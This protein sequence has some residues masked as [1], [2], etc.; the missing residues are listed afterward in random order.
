MCREIWDDIGK[1]ASAAEPS[2][3]SLQ[4][5][6]S[7]CSVAVTSIPSHFPSGAPLKHATVQQP[8]DTLFTSL[9]SSLPSSVHRQADEGAGLLMQLQQLVESCGLPDE[10]ASSLMNWFT[11]ELHS[12]SCTVSLPSQQELRHVDSV[13]VS[14]ASDG[15]TGGM[16]EVR[17]SEM[18]CTQNNADELLSASAMSAH[19][20]ATLCSQE[21]LHSSAMA[22]SAERA[23]TQSFSSH[24][25]SA[26][27]MQPPSV[28]TSIDQLSSLAHL[29]QLQQTY[30]ESAANALRS[31]CILQQQ[32]VSAISTTADNGVSASSTATGTPALD[33]VHSQSSDYIPHSE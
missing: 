3:A 12:I 26:S 6:P 27:E 28:A 1:V 14:S 7:H 33:A 2:A 21:P 29:Q 30:L 8:S 31:L 22:A 32:L 4:H 17:T 15:A 13:H 23:V 25:Y 9:P 10:A 5:Q 16:S 18:Y 19:V 20:P 11:Q 24:Q